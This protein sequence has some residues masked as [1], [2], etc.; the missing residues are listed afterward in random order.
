M[1]FTLDEIDASWHPFFSQRIH[2]VE[3][4]LNEIQ[5]SDFTPARVDIFRAFQQPLSDI[6][7][8]IFGQDPYPGVGV[9]DGLAFSSQSGNPIPASLRNIFKE[10][11]DDLRFETPASPDLSTWASHGVLLLNRTLTTAVGER[12]AHVGSQWKSFTLDVA[13]ELGTRD[14]VAIFWGT[15]ARELAPYFTYR[16]ESPHPSPLSAHRG[17]FGSK[18]FSTANRLLTEIGKEPVEWKLI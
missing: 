10:Y 15:Y 2:L 17:F 16:V 18:P 9:A 14:V 11:V 7:I 13:R 6:R 3:Q 12:N 8:V 1:N 4:L 5:G